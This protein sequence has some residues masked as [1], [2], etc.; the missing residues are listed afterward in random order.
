[1]DE[2]GWWTFSPGTAGHACEVLGGKTT[3]EQ[4]PS[5]TSMFKCR[6]SYTKTAFWQKNGLVTEE[7][8]KFCVFCTLIAGFAIYKD[9]SILQF[10]GR[11]FFPS[12]SATLV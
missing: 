7:L 6:E 2:D 1:M 3:S 9:T 4:T 12:E 5:K 10:Y 8:R 11:L